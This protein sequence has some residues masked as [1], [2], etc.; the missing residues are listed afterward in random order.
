M[1]SRKRQKES[2]TTKEDMA[3]YTERRFGDDGCVF[4]WR[5]RHCQRSCLRRRQLVAQ[6][7]AWNGRN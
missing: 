4:E 5:E 6:C 7:S 2:W 1:D 3:G